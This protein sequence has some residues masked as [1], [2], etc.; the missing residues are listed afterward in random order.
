MHVIQYQKA[1]PATDNYRWDV[2]IF[3]ASNPPVNIGSVA[4]VQ[5]PGGTGIPITSRLPYPVVLTPGNV[6]A[7][8]VLFSYN[9]QNWGSNDQSHHS[10]FGRYDNGKREGDTGFTC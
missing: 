10:N 1:N 4:S 2:T 8:A 3:D 5:A 7:D 9:G 6:D